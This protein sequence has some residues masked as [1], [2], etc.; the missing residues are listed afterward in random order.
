VLRPDA[1]RL[2]VSGGAVTLEL[3]PYG[4]AWL[5]SPDQVR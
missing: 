1:P 2:E 5:V 3:P 4:T